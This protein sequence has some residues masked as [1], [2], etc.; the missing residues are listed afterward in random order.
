M[1]KKTPAIPFA[2][3]ELGEMRH[4][5]AFF[6]GDDEASRVLLPFLRDG[7]E[8]GD[9][10]IHVVNPGERCKHLHRLAAAGVDT[11]AAEQSGQLEFRTNTGAYLRDG[12]FDQDRMLEVFEQLASGNVRGDFPLSRIV[13]HMDWACEVRS[14]IDDLV[15]FEARVNGVWS[16]HEDAV[17]C[18][19]DLAKFGG[20]TVV[21][22]MRTHP[23][24][25]IGG[26]LQQNPFFVPP[27][28]FLRELRQRRAGQMPRSETEL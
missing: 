3:S 7:F 1:H 18:V 15:E 21:D 5:C 25:V 23:M 12:R 22:I 2:G 19:Y 24:I 14:H 13:C 6:N 9:K 16:R 28:E 4:A 26:I 27:E 10:V 17:I 8:R 20:D 11:T